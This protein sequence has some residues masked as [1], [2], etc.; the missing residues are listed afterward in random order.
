MEKQ[1]YKKVFIDGAITPGFIGE[2][3]SKHSS[4]TGIGAHNIF[5]GQVR[6]D[7]I[8]GKA[9]KAIEYSAYKEMAENELYRIRE[10]A[11]KEFDLVCLHIYHSLGIVKT[12]EICFYVFISS[13]HRD[14]CYKASRFIVE[15]VKKNV[16]IF[17]KELFEDESFVWKV[18]KASENKFDIF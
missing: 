6:A 17:G 18:N 12:G 7:I 5:L 14:A 13:A 10:T 1:K 3:I 15:E 8:E 4:K 2:S 9:V 11:F 16:P